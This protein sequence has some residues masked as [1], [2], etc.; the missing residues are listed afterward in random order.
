[1][2]DGRHRTASYVAF[3]LGCEQAGPMI[4]RE[5]LRTDPTRLG[6][7]YPCRRAA[8]PRP[9]SRLGRGDT[10]PARGVET[11][12][13][14]ALEMAEAEAEVLDV[15]ERAFVATLPDSSVELLL[16]DNSQAHL[17][18]MVSSPTEQAPMCGVDSPHHCPAARRAQLQQFDDSDALDACPTL[19]GRAEGRRC[20]VCVPVSIMGRTVGVIHTTAEVG[21]VRGAG[22]RTS[23]PWRAWPAPASGCSAWSQKPSFKRPPTA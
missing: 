3:E 18:R 22:S 13:A 17:S 14:S 21:I 9:V 7:P 12:L 20:A 23:A 11:R 4:G 2:G 19:R 1:M 15:V 16:A 6:A 8:K 5:T 10:G